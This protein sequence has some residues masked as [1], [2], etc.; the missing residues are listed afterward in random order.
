MNGSEH[1]EWQVNQSKFHAIA[2]NNLIPFKL[3]RS[4]ITNYM[5]QHIDYIMRNFCYFKDIATISEYLCTD[6]GQF[7]FEFHNRIGMF[8]KI[9]RYNGSDSMNDGLNHKNVQDIYEIDRIADDL[10]A[11]KIDHQSNRCNQYVYPLSRDEW[12]IE[13]QLNIFGVIDCGSNVCD[14]DEEMISLHE[15]LRKFEA[16]ENSGDDN[17]EYLAFNS[18]ECVFRHFFEVLS[19]H[20]K[21]H[22]HYMVDALDVCFIKSVIRFL[23][24]EPA[25]DFFG[26]LLKQKGFNMQKLMRVLKEARPATMMMDMRLYEALK[27]LLLTDW[28]DNDSGSVSSDDEDFIYEEINIIGERLVT[29]FLEEDSYFECKQIYDIL[30][31]L[32]CSR[33]C[34]KLKLVEFKKVDIKTVLYI[35]LIVGQ[36]DIIIDDIFQTDAYRA[37]IDMF[38]EHSCCSLVLAPLAMLLITAIKD[39]A[40][41]SLLIKAKFISKFHYACIDCISVDQGPKPAVHALFSHLVYIYPILSFYLNKFDKSQV[42]S[43][44]WVHLCSMMEYY[45]KIE[46]LT[47]SNDDGI[48]NFINE[49]CMN[50]SFARYICHLIIDEMPVPSILLKK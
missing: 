4:V 9:I 31:I 33:R 28:I 49:E 43:D 3:K 6:N 40:K 45:N 11:L 12:M 48:E 8:M 23:D 41:L 37:F 2:R 46:M 29:A 14:A 15:S 30:E 19:F 32:N 36:L 22:P 47:Y 16:R 20:F 42:Q 5:I 38:F 39:T 18:V 10:N 50:E 17:G 44:R 1:K 34:P 13:S 21:N 27:M 26:T 24:F 25:L 7:N 35:R